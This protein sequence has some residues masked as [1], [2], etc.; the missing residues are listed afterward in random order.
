MLKSNLEADKD[1]LKQLVYPVIGA[2]Q[3]VHKQL[4]P[5]LNEYMY[6]DA[7]AIELTLR[8]IPFDKEF[9]FSAEYK[10]YPIDHKHFVDFRVMNG[11]TLVIVECK[12][13]DNLTDAHRQQLWNYMRLTGINI[14]VLYN[15][16]PVYAKCEKYY[17]DASTSRMIVF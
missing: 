17:Y 12:A 5:F 4:G 13:V 1:I 9:Y 11:D 10:G 6:Q 14:G 7:L 2:C 16:A 8:H 3:E 15:F